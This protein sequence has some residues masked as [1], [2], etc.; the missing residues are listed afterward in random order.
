[1]AP[2]KTKNGPISFCFEQTLLSKKQ[3][4]PIKAL[5]LCYT[6][7]TD[8]PNLQGSREFFWTL[9]E[10]R[11]YL[12]VYIFDMK[13]LIEVSPQKSQ[14][15]QFRVSILDFQAFTP[16]RVHKLNS[17]GIINAPTAWAPVL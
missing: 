16:P 6:I 17:N 11:F 8:C 2:P 5:K 1:M 4:G 10:L 3:D 15:F 9:N 12:Y 7:C 13:S 14:Y